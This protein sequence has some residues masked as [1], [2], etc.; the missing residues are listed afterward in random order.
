MDKAIR[1]WFVGYWP[2]INVSFD[3]NLWITGKR[4][5]TDVNYRVPLL[6]IPKAIL[7]KYKDVTPHGTLLPI[8]SNQKMNA[9]LK[10]IADIC[11]IKKRL[12]FHTA[13]HTFST[14]VMLDHGVSVETLSRVLGH[15]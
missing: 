7:N 12:T 15:S 9:Y 11:G 2:N 5:K 10:E 13:R 1:R 3:G 4:A 6:D 8:I 14:S